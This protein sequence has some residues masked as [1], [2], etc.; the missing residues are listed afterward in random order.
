MA[1]SYRV[2]LLG[3]GEATSPAEVRQ[4]MSRLF[5]VP[6]ERIEQLFLKAPIVV[7]SGI[8]RELAEKMVAAIEGCGARARL[9]P[10]PEAA[11]Q[12]A[13][14]GAATDQGA[15]MTCP[16]CGQ[17]QPR[18]VTCVLCGKVVAKVQEA[19]RRQQEAEAKV[20]RRQKPR[21]LQEL[22]LH[23][24]S[25]GE[26]LGA[27]FTMLRERL[28][29]FAGIT[30]LVPSGLF[31]LVAAV[32]G[33]LIYAYMKGSGVSVESLM[34][35][36]MTHQ[37]LPFSPVL[38]VGL[39]MVA[40]SIVMFVMLW[41]Q[42]S[43]TYAVSE[44]HL[45]HEIGVFASYRF[46]LGRLGTLSWTG[47]T[48]GL[49]VMGAGILLAIPAV[50]LGPLGAVGMILAVLYFVFRYILV[51][52]V[53]VLEGLSGG[54]ARSRSQ[55]LISGNVLRLIAMLIIFGLVAGLIKLAFSFFDPLLEEMPQPFQA[56]GQVT[57]GVLSGT[58]GSALPSMG[59]CLF[60]YDTRLRHD[61]SLTYEDI[62]RGLEAAP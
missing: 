28:A 26:M 54:E 3:G 43:L 29:V 13:A 62:A 11:A 1:E 38:F 7:K 47:F 55:Q 45:G 10:V 22:N 21:V 58:F 60:Y 24:M 2:V 25:I 19:I 59:M 30:V 52:K 51:E 16:A 53:V 49:I 48:T 56:M 15:T 44:R 32:F 5:K 57:V 12:A 46:A 42:A 31:L 41:E 9:E 17:E 8:G 4:R 39:I 36:A 34:M 6:E 35:A 27:A 37:E 50:F 23:P 61:G 33:G 40:T 20:E 18:A 14:V